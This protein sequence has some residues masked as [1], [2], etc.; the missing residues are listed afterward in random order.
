MVYPVTDWQDMLFKKFAVNERLNVSLSGGGKTA[1]YYVSGAFNQDNGVLKVNGRNNFNNN[2][3]LKNFD[4]RSNIDLDLNPTT[5]LTV[6]MHGNFDDYNGPL[7][8]GADYYRQ[9]LRTNPVMFPAVYEPDEA[10]LLAKHILFGNVEDG[11]YSNP[12]ADLVKGYRQYSTSKI[13]AQLELKQNF[14]FITKGLEARIMFNTDRG[15]ILK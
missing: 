11:S 12:Y 9:V 5:K 2:I 13:L 10:N 7:G 14:D 4:L 1:R 8:Y 15:L 6:R 3:N